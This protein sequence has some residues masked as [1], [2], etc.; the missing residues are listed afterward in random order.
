MPWQAELSFAQTRAAAELARSGTLA[1]PTTLE[2]GW[3]STTPSKS[4]L[5]PDG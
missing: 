3:C 5:C 2:I 4:S 1:D